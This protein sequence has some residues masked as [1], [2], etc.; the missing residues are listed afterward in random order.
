M[1]QKLGIPGFC[2]LRINA[3]RR[4]AHRTQQNHTLSDIYHELAQ[5]LKLDLDKIRSI[6]NLELSLERENVIP[7]KENIDILEIDTILISDMYL[8]EIEIKDFLRIA[9]IAS[10]YP[11]IKTSSGKTTGRVWQKLLHK[12]F[13]VNQQLKT[14]LVDDQYHLVGLAC[15]RPDLERSLSSHGA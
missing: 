4:A 8:S 12:S 14:Y 6:R 3:S 11:L 5:I 2:R 13:V 9:G 15:P 1:E 10:H 7:I